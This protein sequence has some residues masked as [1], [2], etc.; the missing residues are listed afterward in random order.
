MVVVLSTSFLS[1]AEVWVE[2]LTSDWLS[3]L[4]LLAGFKSAAADA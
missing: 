3:S 1:D 2:L 4:D